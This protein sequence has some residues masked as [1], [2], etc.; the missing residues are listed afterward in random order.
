MKKYSAYTLLIAFVTILVFNACDQQ[1][2]SPGYEFMPDMYRSPAIE[3]YVDYNNNDTMSARK[4]V[5]GT[6]ARGKMPFTFD[7][8]QDG[9][10]KA[11]EK[12]TNPIPCTDDIMAEGKELYE[13]FCDHCHGKDGEGQGKLVELGKFPPPPSYLNG[14]SS[15]GGK[16]KDLSPGKIYHTIYYGLNLMGSHAS[17]IQ[18]DDRWKIV[19]YVESLQGKEKCEGDSGNEGETE[20]TEAE[21]EA[22]ETVEENT[23]ADENKEEDSEES[24]T[25]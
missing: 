12:L 9:Y 17:Q 4:P 23:S 21:N 1:E 20:M 16:M 5:E 25:E 15:R 2:N 10:L 22:D 19:H 11:G 24:E 7:D 3:P 8:S 18:E 6:I 13:I 14:N